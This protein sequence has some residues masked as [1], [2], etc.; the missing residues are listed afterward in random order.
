MKRCLIRPLGLI[1]IIIKIAITFAVFLFPQELVAAYPFM[2]F[3]PVVV[4]ASAYSITS[5]SM[6]KAILICTV[7]FLICTLI[8]FTIKKNKKILLMRMWVVRV[9]FG[10]EVLCYFLSLLWG[11]LLIGKLLGILFNCI[12]LGQV[13]S[14]IST[15]AQGS[16]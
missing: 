14:S 2:W 15:L 6:L 11:S 13:K 8:I 16:S 5:K 4:A 10:G 7:A 3:F 1:L 12:I 9:F